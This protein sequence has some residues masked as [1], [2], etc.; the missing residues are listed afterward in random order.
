M[1]GINSTEGLKPNET[2]FIGCKGGPDD[3]WVVKSFCDQPTVT[4]ENI[5]SG[6]EVGGAT[7]CLNLQ[8]FRLLKPQG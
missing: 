2:L 5:K 7:G 4:L 3:V 6:E 8:Q 1:K